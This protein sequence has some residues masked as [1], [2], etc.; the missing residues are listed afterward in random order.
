MKSQ[1]AKFKSM[2]D[3]PLNT[4]LEALHTNEDE[5]YKLL[6]LWID[7][8]HLS[9]SLPLY[10]QLRDKRNAKRQERIRQ[11]REKNLKFY[12]RL[13]D[14]HLSLAKISQRM[15]FSPER[16]DHFLLKC[17][18]DFDAKGLSHEEIAKELRLPL[19]DLEALIDDFEA[20]RE[21]Q[22]QAR[23]KRL[24][25][26]RRYAKTHLNGIRRDLQNNTSDYLIYD[27]EAIQCPDEPIEISIIDCHGRVV[28]D[29]L[30]QPKNKI[31]WRIAKLTGITDAMV[32]GQPSIH[33]FM[34]QLKALT[35]GKHM[36][37]WGMDY[38]SILFSKAMEETGV[39]LSCTFG[40][41]QRI[42]TGLLDAPNQIALYTAAGETTQNHR[43]LDDCQMV[44]KILQ[45]D[46]ADVAKVLQP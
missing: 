34:P 6:K 33:D 43:A 38:D 11:K 42:H 35:A 45:R 9:K 27:V 3:K 26:N 46:L 30:I 12:Q 7:Q 39:H 10:I 25:D 4:V 20:Q 21:Q 28:F 41:A 36:L 23:E 40:C 44:L 24:A 32:S 14:D 13:R 1:L 18:E 15:P 37:S 2:Q 5:L 22:A 31:N 8:G 19:G 29:H 16:F 17:Y